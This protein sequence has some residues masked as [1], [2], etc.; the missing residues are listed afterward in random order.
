MLKKALR[1]IKKLKFK[2]KIKLLNLTVLDHNVSKT[3][4]SIFA[5]IW[6]TTQ[7]EISASFMSNIGKAFINNH[8]QGKKWL[9]PFFSKNINIDKKN[10]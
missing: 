6:S 1:F 3:H 5:L 10:I 7:V 4:L 9:R 2:V 8:G